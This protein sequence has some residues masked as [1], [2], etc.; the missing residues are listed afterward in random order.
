MKEIP[1]LFSTPMVKAILEGR[2]TQ[3]RR[4]LKKQPPPGYERHCWYNAPR[5]GFTHDPA[6][7]DNWHT[8]KSPFGKIG[9]ILW[10]RETWQ[11]EGMPIAPEGDHDELI[12]RYKA[13]EKEDLL[14][15]WRPSIFMPKNAA[16][17]WLQVIDIR[18]ERL[19]DISEND[20]TAEGIKVI[21]GKYKNYWDSADRFPT[22]AH[23][24]QSFKTLWQVINSEESW[25]ANPW[26]WVILFKVLSTTGKPDKF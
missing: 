20:A 5:Y 16:R 8:I 13:T 18:V 11:A 6:P 22:W 14:S 10:V 15:K 3:T 24:R 23:A 9:D 12:Y 19:Q 4:I 1:I 7:S 25:E 2:K 26:V 21:N 17:I